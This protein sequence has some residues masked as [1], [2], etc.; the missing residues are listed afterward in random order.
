MNI[1]A[2][3]DLHLTQDENKSMEVFG[4][5][6]YEEKIFNFW[7]ENVNKD[8]IV[9]IAGDIS[10]AMTL[11]DALPDLDLLHNMKGT[12][13]LLKGN[14]DY[15][16]GSIKKLNSLYDDMI[17]LQNSAYE[18]DDYVICG[19]RLWLS[20]N[21]KNFTDQDNKIYKREMVRLE[22]SLKLGQKS[23]KKIIIMSHFPPTNDKKE[24]SGFV[25][26]MKK[27]DITHAIYGH[28]HGEHSFNNSLIGNHYGIEFH[29]VS[30]DYLKF[31]LAKI[32]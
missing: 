8:D 29:L 19:S 1:Y 15:W 5:T 14:H 26:I 11:E 17:F 6:N 27:Y 13:V 7:E 25:E 28:L 4:W 16:W 31:K 24:E 30:C 12:K 2:V 20:P 23:G 32:I 3:G 21:E 10:W 18:I 9:L 22:N